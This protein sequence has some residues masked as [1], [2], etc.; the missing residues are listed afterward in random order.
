MEGRPKIPFFPEHNLGRN[1]ALLARCSGDLYIIT[2]N[3]SL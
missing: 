3:Q 2:D 1:R